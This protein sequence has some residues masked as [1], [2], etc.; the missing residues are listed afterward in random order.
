MTIINTKF[1][2]LVTK[3]A[4]FRGCGRNSASKINAKLMHFRRLE[5][6]DPLAQAKSS[7][8]LD[9]EAKTSISENTI[10]PCSIGCVAVRLVGETKRKETFHLR[11]T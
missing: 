4:E 6:T 9:K 10:G 2:P 3:A 7:N 11:K 5:C 1:S 8:I